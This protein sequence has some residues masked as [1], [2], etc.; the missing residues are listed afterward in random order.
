MNAAL[1]IARK[2]LAEIRRDGR[3]LRSAI[4]VLALFAVAIAAGAKH[5]LDAHRIQQD[6]QNADRRIWLQQGEKTPHGAAHQGMYAFNPSPLLSAFDHGVSS[7]L[8]SVIWM[9]A[10]KQNDSMY[11]P[12]QDASETQRLGGMSA[13]TILQLLVP[14][15]IVF[16]SFSAFAGERENGTLRQI[17]SLGISPS[18][19]LAGKALGIGAAVGTMLAV[20]VAAGAIA[21]AVTDMKAFMEA[22][23]RAALLAIFYAIYLLAFLA[24]SLGVSAA[25]KT[26]RQAL[27]VLIG[28]WIF[29]GMLAPKL[30]AE[31]AERL[32]PTPSAIA[33][34][35]Q[36]AQERKLSREKGV[37]GHNMDHPGTKALV[38]KLLKE[39]NAER[40]EDLPVNFSGIALDE[41]E[42]SAYP[43]YDRIFGGLWDGYEAQ[44]KVQ[45]WAGLAA[46]MLSMRAF[47]ASVA[48]TDFLQY[49]HFAAAAEAHRRRFIERINEDVTRNSK[50]GETYTRGHDLWQHAPAFSY[51]P[52]GTMWAVRNALPSA[53]VLIVWTVVAWIAAIRCVGRLGFDSQSGIRAAA[54][55][56][57][58]KH[59]DRARGLEEGSAL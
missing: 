22:L 45:Q 32:F 48:G 17:L 5:R 16:M 13:A 46:P 10:H 40:L 33:F 24:I 38:A 35:E 44:E 6:A 56:T 14:L 29:N 30:S 3:F 12:I 42:K 9:E 34:E 37:D 54:V 20:A 58:A 15:V 31:A 18:Q 50:Y 55:R 59:A 39:Y 52:P 26:S 21:F 36:I 41:G 7:C 28:F 1:T 19:L 27:V 43:I 8:G 57:P 53:V 47:S 4:L 49:R 25:S 51:T 23:P 11:R 2:E